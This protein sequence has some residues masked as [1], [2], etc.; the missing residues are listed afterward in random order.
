MAA[1]PWLLAQVRTRATQLVEDWS[2]RVYV[3]CVVDGLEAEGIED[4]RHLS[5]DELDALIIRHTV[6]P[7]MGDDEDVA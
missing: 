3:R 6:A 7:L 2:E 5:A 4:V 1:D